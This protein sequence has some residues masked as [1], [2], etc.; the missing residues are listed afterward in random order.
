MKGK[1]SNGE[2]GVG[3]GGAGQGCNTGII[4]NVESLIKDITIENIS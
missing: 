4:N 1:E 2:T 3:G